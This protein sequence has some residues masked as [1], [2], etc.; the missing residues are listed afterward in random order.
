MAC[1]CR[2][3]CCCRRRRVARHGRTLSGMAYRLDG[4]E[5][6][7]SIGRFGPLLAHGGR[8]HGEPCTGDFGVC[9]DWDVNAWHMAANKFVKFA[10]DLRATNI[11]PE[12]GEDKSKWTE[13]VRLGEI[14][15]QAAEKL[16]GGDLGW[17]DSSKVATLQEVQRLAKT[18]LEFWFQQLEADLNMKIKV[19]ESQDPDEIPPVT[20][21]PEFPSLWPAFGASIAVVGGAIVLAIA[22][23]GR[24]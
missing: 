17:L 18:A 2:G 21:L 7:E 8:T 12:Y 14:A 10:R 3:A 4:A 5:V 20:P 9:T 24:R 22:L 15:Y 6:G 13:K 23:G 19:P 16:R 11:I 1:G